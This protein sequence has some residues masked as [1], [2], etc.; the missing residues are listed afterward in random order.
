MSLAVVRRVAGIE[1]RRKP[2]TII[3]RSV[4]AVNHVTAKALGF[5]IPTSLLLRTNDVI[6]RSHDLAR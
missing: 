4:D 1:H 6:G 2:Q 3:D 5:T